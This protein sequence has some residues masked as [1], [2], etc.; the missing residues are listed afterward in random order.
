M[1]ALVDDSLAR[2]QR[3]LVLALRLSVAVHAA[4][5]VFGPGM[6]ATPCRRALTTPWRR[7]RRRWSAPAAAACPAA[8]QTRAQAKPSLSLSLSR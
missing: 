5:L 4:L 1:T 2:D 3:A 8:T 7:N 6:R